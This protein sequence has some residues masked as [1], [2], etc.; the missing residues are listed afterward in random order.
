MIQHPGAVAM[1][2]L[3]DDDVILIRQYRTPTGG[4]LLELPAGKLDEG[5]TELEIAASRELQ[6]EVGFRPG[7]LEPL[8]WFWMAP[9]YADERIWVFLATDLEPVALDPAGAEEEVA[10]V[11]RVPFREALEMIRRGEIVDAKTICGLHL[12]AAAR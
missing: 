5:D 3:I 2:P 11:V 9:G 8:G 12:A 4:L 7:R 1:V 10:E 6:E